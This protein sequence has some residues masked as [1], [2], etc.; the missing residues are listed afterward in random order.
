MH[1]CWVCRARLKDACMLAKVMLGQQPQPLL[2]SNDT[3]CRDVMRDAQ[4][5][6]LEG[7]AE[8]RLHACR[9]GG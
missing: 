1:S 9:S 3:I 8:K 5:L 6:G 7:K 4:L 2:S